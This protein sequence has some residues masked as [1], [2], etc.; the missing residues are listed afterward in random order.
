MEPSW[1]YYNEIYP[2]VTSEK[3]DFDEL[4]P[5]LESVACNCLVLHES[6]EIEG[7]ES[8]YDWKYVKN[9]SGYDIYR[10]IEV[11]E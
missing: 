8:D 2:L 3:I 10:K 1:N 4:F 6:K 9:V 7:D 5:V 11:K